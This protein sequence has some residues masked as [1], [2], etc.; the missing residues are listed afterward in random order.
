MGGAVFPLCYLPGAKHLAS[1]VAQLIK[2]MPAMRETW[3]NSYAEF[4][5]QADYVG[6]TETCEHQDPGERSSDPTRD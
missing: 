6:T 2:N 3:V 1:L 5:W 4:L